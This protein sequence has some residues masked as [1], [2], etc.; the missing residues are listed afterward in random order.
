MKSSLCS[1]TVLVFA[2]G[3]ISGVGNEQEQNTTQLVDLAQLP[4][5]ASD[6]LVLIINNQS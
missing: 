4:R 6:E 5:Q 1:D 2:S 3:L